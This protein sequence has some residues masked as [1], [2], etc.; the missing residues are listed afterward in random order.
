MPV[1]FKILISLALILAVQRI[2]G[3]LL[4]A[5]TAGTLLLAFWAGHT[6]RSFGQVVVTSFFSFDNY[7]LLAVI[8]LVIWLSLQMDRTGLLKD[9]VST[10]T[11]IFS[12]R[13]AMAILPAL[14]GLLPMPGGA[15]FSAPLVDDCDSEKKLDP[16]LKTRINFWFR[17]IWEYWWPLYPGVIVAMDITG[18]EPPVFIAVMLPLTLFSVGIGYF[19]L[20]RKVAKTKS[21]RKEPVKV[22][23]GYLLP[24][25]LL[26]VVYILI[27]LLFPAV[28]A[29]NNYLP[30]AIAIIAA[31]ICQHI[32]RPLGG[33]DW[34]KILLSRKAFVMAA[35]IAVIR[36]YGAFIES[37]IPGGDLLI[38]QL[39]D[40]LA[41]A[42][43]PALLLIILLPFVSSLTTGV[44]V[45]Y[46]G[47]SM[48]IVMQLIG[49]DAPAG[50][51][52]STAVLA[53]GSGYVALMLSP[54][55]VC[56]IV[57][58]Q[59][60]GTGLLTS[61]RKLLLPAAVLLAGVFAWSFILYS[62][63]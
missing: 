43:I 4:I 36:I 3:K 7:M 20:L 40:E 62:V 50:L 38:N 49:A 19:F 44:A 30:M 58:N 57:T 6:F 2:S 34:L 47:A 26:I 59:H 22:F 1:I 61:I 23:L 42:G 53:Y 11:G 10:A 41:L 27:Q 54:V 46:V 16:M 28:K 48:P 32:L 8:F 12:N 60:F 37:R 9:L 56:L 5:V 35:I 33:R 45:G 24:V 63:L 25:F 39:K 52:L 13:T 55:H 18:L 15:I 51:L 29:Q 31:I 21:D 17:H 14:I